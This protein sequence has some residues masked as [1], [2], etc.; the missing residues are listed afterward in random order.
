MITTYF[1]S[2]KRLMT[3]V[4]FNRIE[5]QRGGDHVWT[6]HTSE[7]CFQVKKVSINTPLITVYFPEGVQPRAY[8]K[9]RSR[10]E[11]KGD[12]AYLW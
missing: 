2:K 12:V 11:V 8:F 10:V 7:G 1:T 6:V 9:G 5:M 4:H 3:K